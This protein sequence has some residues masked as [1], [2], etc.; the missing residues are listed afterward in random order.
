MS[1]L[2]DIVIAASANY[3][4]SFFTSVV[5]IVCN[6]GFKS[7][8]ISE[9]KVSSFDLGQLVDR[10]DQL[11]VTHRVADALGEFVDTLIQVAVFGNQ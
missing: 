6:V 11:N 3:R 8:E 10:L 9:K 1:K 5:S 4:C 2:V 7:T